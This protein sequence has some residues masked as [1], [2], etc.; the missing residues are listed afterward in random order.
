MLV[1]FQT[2]SHESIVFLGAIA[3]RLLVMMGHSATVPGAIEAKDVPRYLETLKKSIA[4]EKQQAK[5]QPLSDAKEEEPDVSIVH[6]AWPLIALLEA[7]VEHR[8]DVLW[9]A[10]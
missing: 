7:A 5:D 1:T 8:T 9:D 6:R 2:D 10:S 3:Q 4:A